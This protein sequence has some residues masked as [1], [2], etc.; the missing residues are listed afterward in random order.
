MISLP[1][2]N[3]DQLSA[4][5]KQ[6]REAGGQ[7][8]SIAVMAI[9]FLSVMIILLSSIDIGYLFYMKRNLQ[10]AVDLAAL[11]GTQQLVS[12][13]STDCIA[14]TSA[15]IGNAQTN[16]FTII[17]SNVTCGFWD[18]LN[19]LPPGYFSTSATANVTSLNA[20]KIVDTQTVPTFFGLFPGKISAQAIASGS[21]PVAAF[22][23]G[24]GLLSLCGTPSSVLAP[25]LTGLGGSSVCLSLVSSS[26][27]VGAQISLLGLLN[28][29]GVSVG[30]VSDVAAVNVTLLQLVNASISALTPAQQASIRTD[31]GPVITLAGSTQFALGKILN[32]DTSTGLSALNAQVNVLDLLNV[33]TLQFANGSSFINLGASVP[34]LVGV[35]LKLIEPPKMAAGGIGTSATSAQ[36][37]LMINANVPGLAFLPIYVDLAPG[38]AT[39]TGLQCN[40]PQSATFSVQTGVGE[41][42]LANNQ[43]GGQPFSCP[44]VSNQANQVNVLGLLSLGINASLTGSGVSETLYPPP[45]SGVSPN[46]N[47]PSSVTVGSSMSTILGNIIQ[48][49][50]TPPKNFFFGGIL[51]L[52]NPV[53]SVLGPILNPILSVVGGA[54]DSVFSLLGIGIGQSTL[55]L[56]SITCGNVKLVY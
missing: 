29:L 37:R 20:V 25:L 33:G 8:G 46:P 15:A 40:A 16:G 45:A 35:S 23:L 21:S 53:L 24:T 10:K 55:S 34:G 47:T 56:S 2:P 6:R 30:S 26:G 49:G 39:L 36:L 12:S 9:I 32:L 1:S 3:A 31:L 41:V 14:P 18:P 44:D 50:P 54:L 52:L 22:S 7:R 19:N 51:S 5:R 38:K 17:A 11:A 4:V 28:N 42:C 13:N 43:S 27:L 48:P